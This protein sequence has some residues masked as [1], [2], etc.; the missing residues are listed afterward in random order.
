MRNVQWLLRYSPASGLK[1]AERV[2]TRSLITTR[3]HDGRW[4]AHLGCLVYE[5]SDR[6][7]PCR[8]H[9]ILGLDRASIVLPRDCVRL[10]MHMTAPSGKTA[11]FSLDDP[12]DQIP[13]L[14]TY[15][16]REGTR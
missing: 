8:S 14:R 10:G 2:K 13:R 6:H 9:P 12:N 4:P 1:A 5:L 16:V 3:L 11:D 7:Q 15:G